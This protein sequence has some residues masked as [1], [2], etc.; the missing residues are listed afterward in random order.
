MSYQRARKK[1]S[2]NSTSMDMYHFLITF[3][4]PLNAKEEYV[5]ECS[6]YKIGNILMI[7]FQLNERP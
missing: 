5:D 2:T 7:L 1:N 4:Y 6:T 3:G